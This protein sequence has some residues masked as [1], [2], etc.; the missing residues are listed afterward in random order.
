MIVYLGAVIIM[1][2]ALNY[3]IPS[4]Y[5]T[6]YTIPYWASPIQYHR[7]LLDFNLQEKRIAK[8]MMMMMCVKVLCD[9]FWC[10]YQGFANFMD[11]LFPCTVPAV[12]ILIVHL[13]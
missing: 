12:R 6:N 1:T 3:Y 5:A 10:K 2:R 8:M 11:I 4:L 13:S 7:L 9:C